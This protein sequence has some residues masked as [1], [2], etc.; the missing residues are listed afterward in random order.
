V[1]WL[2][3]GVK[4]FEG[5]ALNYKHHSFKEVTEVFGKTLMRAKYQSKYIF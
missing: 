3:S 4:F 2:T 5:S 1:K